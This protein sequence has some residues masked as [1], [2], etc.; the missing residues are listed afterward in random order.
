[1]VN[2]LY[3]RGNFRGAIRL[4]E[5]FGELG[6]EEQIAVFCS[7]Q[8]H[9]FDPGLYDGTIQ[10]VC[11]THGHLIPTADDSGHRE[12]VDRAFAE[13][14]GPLDLPSLNLLIGGSR[15]SGIEMPASQAL[16]LWLKDAAPD[17]ATMVL[18]RARALEA[19]CGKRRP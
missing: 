2:V 13:V 19:E 7:F 16:L 3:G 9:P 17:K 18:H 15:W 10:D 11:R 1:M 5:L 14:F 6:R 4:E 12:C 8:M